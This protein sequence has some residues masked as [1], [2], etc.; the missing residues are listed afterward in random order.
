MRESDRVNIRRKTDILQC[1]VGRPMRILVVDDEPEIYQLVTV[2]L[3]SWGYDV[4]T[5]DGGDEAL[6]YLRAGHLVDIVITDLAM[7]GMLGTELLQQV[8]AFDRG[9]EVIVMTGYGSIPSAVDA[10]RWIRRSAARNGMDSQGIIAERIN[11]PQ[12]TA[13]TRYSQPTRVIRPARKTRI[14]TARNPAPFVVIINW[15]VERRLN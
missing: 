6:E 2:P 3:T 5:A 14:A 15:N 8:K 11:I 10:V 13:S 1:N 7:P 4:V 12:S 9:I